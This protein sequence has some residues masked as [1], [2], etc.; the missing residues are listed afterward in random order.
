ME[1][2]GFAGGYV[3]SPTSDQEAINF[4]MS[5]AVSSTGI[6]LPCGGVLTA[7]GTDT[8]SAARPMLEQEMLL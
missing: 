6:R 2:N 7:S 4:K 3:N 8:L 5:S 1:F